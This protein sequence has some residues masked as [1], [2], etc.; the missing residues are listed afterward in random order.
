[1]IAETSDK[2]LTPSTVWLKFIVF[3]F[4]PTSSI[5][6]SNVVPLIIS[7][8]LPHNRAVNS[9]KWS[10]GTGFDTRYHSRSIS[11]RA[12]VRKLAACNAR[13]HCCCSALPVTNWHTWPIDHW[14]SSWRYPPPRDHCHRSRMMMPFRQTY[15]IFGQTGPRRYSHHDWRSSPI[16]SRSSGRPH[17]LWT[18]LPVE[19]GTFI[20]LIL[21]IITSIIII[22]CCSTNTNV[23]NYIYFVCTRQCTLNLALNLQ[24]SQKSPYQNQWNWST[25]NCLRHDHFRRCN[26]Y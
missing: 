12:G 16:A 8:I 10:T 24:K 20:F 23:G 11:A 2:I 13:S 3:R 25:A 4:P 18:S 21:S 22:T 19:K 14:A 17:S 7:R 15:P 5:W 9:H 6:I 1:M 26:I